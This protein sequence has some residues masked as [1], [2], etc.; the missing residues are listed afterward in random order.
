MSPA[1]TDY[2]DVAERIRQFYER[3]PDG[4]LQSGLAPQLFMVGDKTFVAYHALAYRTPDDPRP[5][6]GWAWEPV[7]GPTPFTKDSELQ[8]AETSAWGRAIV[9]LGFE[10]KHI[11]SANEVRNRQASPERGDG[12]G[13]SSPQPR[14][15]GAKP[16]ATEKPH[17]KGQMS[18]LKTNLAM[19]QE[20]FPEWP[21]EGR[22]WA[23]VAKEWCRDHADAK[24]SSKLSMAEMNDL[25][26][27]LEAKYAELKLGGE[28]PFS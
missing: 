11:A 4:S 5:A 6:H 16:P 2:V 13:G 14:S 22:S 7:P 20:A 9:A 21:G 27:W 23:D 25:N 8:N 18:G 17:T 26:E 24:P 10:T 12:S 15:E 28:V 19:L 3:Y 1:P